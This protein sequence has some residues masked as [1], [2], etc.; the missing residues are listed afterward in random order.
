MHHDVS[1]F[2]AKLPIYCTLPL[3]LTNASNVFSFGVK[4]TLLT[5]G[6]LGDV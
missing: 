6:I 2:L 5:V 3:M 4:L 1:L